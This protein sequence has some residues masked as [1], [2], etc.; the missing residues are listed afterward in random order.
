M[1]VCK[2]A[3]LKVGEAPVTISMVTGQKNGKRY[4]IK[5]MGG[6]APRKERA[7]E[8]ELGGAATA[9]R[10]SSNTA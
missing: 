1:I 3:D 8:R 6:C 10:F 9:T 5:D 2:P 7:T 4:R